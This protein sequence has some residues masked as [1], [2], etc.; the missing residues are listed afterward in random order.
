M[1]NI[2]D[3]ALAIVK[4]YLA[5]LLVWLSDQTYTELLKRDPDHLLIKLSQHL[6]F[7]PLETA[8]ATYHHATGPGVTPIHPMPRLVRALVVGSL[9]HWSLREL[10]WHIRFNLVVKWFVGYPIFALGPDHS[11][12]ERFELWVCFKQHRAYF[13]EILCQIDADFPDQRQA[14]QIG[15][16]YALCANAAKESLVQLIRHTC[17][18]LLAALRKADAA[19]ESAVGTQLDLT[20]LWGAK[21]EPNEFHLTLAER[22]CR[23]QRTV[24]AA[25]DCIRWVRRQLDEPTAL[26]SAPRTLVLE[27]LT[28]LEKIIADEVCVVRLSVGPTVGS[29]IPPPVSTANASEPSAPTTSSPSPTQ[30]PPEAFQPHVTRRA[31]HPKGSYRIGSATDPEATYRVHGSDKLDFGYNVNVAVTDHFVREVHTDTGAQPD[32]VAIPDMLRD[33]AEYHHSVPPKFI[34]DSAAG[35]GKTRARVTAA[36]NGQTQLVAH[37]PPSPPTVRFT[38]DR[39]RLLADGKTLVCP[40]G[41]TTPI[42]YRSSRDEGLNFRFLAVHCRDCPLWTQCRTQKPGSKE[43]RYVY[44]SDYRGEVEA[45]QVYNQSA[46]FLADMRHRPLVERIIAALVRYNGARSARRRGTFR[47]D[48]QAKMNAMAYNLKKWMHLLR[49]QQARGSTRVA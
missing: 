20:A 17:R 46:D 10:E 2:P 23:L 22:A 44:V 18:R 29:V 13:D 40:H 35:A 45:A 16:T 42:A 27:W 33:E 8:C 7:G 6:N 49:S 15:D 14:V 37:L 41:Q 25:Q 1:S 26:K 47:C 38:P 48:F 5:E 30:E 32:A 34:Y 3:V 36:T 11:T 12:L 39:F 9:Y 28:Y 43:I 24:L 31:T 21:D 19:R 4:P